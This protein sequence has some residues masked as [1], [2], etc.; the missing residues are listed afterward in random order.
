MY[1]PQSLSLCVWEEQPLPLHISNSPML[2]QSARSQK[3]MD[4]T[5]KTMSQNKSFALQVLSSGIL[6]QRW[7]VRLVAAVYTPSS[8][9]SLLSPPSPLAELRPPLFSLL[10][11][12]FCCFGFGVSFGF[13]YD[14]GDWVQYL[15]LCHWAT[16][17]VACHDLEVS[18]GSTVWS[19]FIMLSEFGK[20][21][22]Q[23]ISLIL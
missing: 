18:W 1:S 6:S 11:L 9:S 20:K 4:G 17:I 2:C 5:P 22:I 23:V 10:L 13:V 19:D 12:L 16:Y 14:A 21:K 8:F 3:S 7:Q 15:M